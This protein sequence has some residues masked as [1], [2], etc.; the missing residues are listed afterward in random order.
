VRRLL[1]QLHLWLGVIIGLYVLVIC[2]TGAALVFRIDMQR[3]LNPELFTASAGPLA[4]PV[5]IL[6]S[7]ARAYPRH[8][9]SGVDAPTTLRPTYLAYVTSGRDFLT[10]LVD[11]VSTKVLGV[12]PEQPL[13]RTVQRLHFDLLGGRS[14]RLANGAG[15]FGILLLGTTGLAIWWTSRAN[16]RRLTWQ[17]HRTIGIWALA[18]ITMWAITGLYFVFPSEFRATVNRLSPITV[19]RAPASGAAEAAA[20]HPRPTW[21]E[22]IARASEGRSDRF[23]ARV[24]LPSSDR[25]AVLVMFAGRRPTPA[26]SDLEAVYLDQ[27]T[28]ALIAE[29]PQ[30]RTMGDVVMSWVI[31]LHVGGFGSEALRWVWFVLALAPAMLVVT[32]LMMWWS[33]VI[34]P[35]LGR[36]R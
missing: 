18:A 4:D 14:G 13:V 1:F 11:P 19:S 3:A 10:V 29:A 17:L 30:A 5:A 32:G 36:A 7:V 35:R 33:R 25:S 9:L 2:V 24:V 22:L 26:G 6:E 28:G 34:R 15:A 27:F 16:W 12:L 21:R 23:V 20:G 8:Q 31:P